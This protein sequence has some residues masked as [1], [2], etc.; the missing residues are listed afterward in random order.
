[1]I[2]P[3][4]KLVRRLVMGES[5]EEKNITPKWHGSWDWKETNNVTIIWN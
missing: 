4:K 1:M 5:N 3:I 2:V